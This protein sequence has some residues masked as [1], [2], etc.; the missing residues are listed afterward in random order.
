MISCQKFV[1]YLW[2]YV[3]WTA[4]SLGKEFLLGGYE[5]IEMVESYLEYR[6]RTME[7]MSL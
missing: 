7:E 5:L 4:L 6:F 1:L 2:G 3:L